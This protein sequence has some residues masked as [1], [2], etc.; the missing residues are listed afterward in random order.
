M[1]F[2]DQLGRP[3][4]LNKIPERL[5]SLVP[6]Q[7]EL[8]ADLGL[9]AYLAGITKFCVHPANLRKTKTIVGGTKK[10]HFDKIKAL[11]P[12]L[13]LCNKEENTKEMVTELEK[14][15]PVH[16]SDI[17][18]VEDNYSL[19]KMYAEML[20]CRQEAS[21]MIDTI[22]K[23]RFGFDKNKTHP[24]TVL[25]FIW[26]DPWMSVGR[27]T[28]IHQMLTENNL[29]NYCEKEVRYPE[30]DLHRLKPGDAP[31][32]IF[33]SSEPYPFKKKHQK[34]L[35]ALFP[36]SNIQLVNG[37]FFSWYGSRLTKAY[38]YFKEL[39]IKIMKI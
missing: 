20:D 11:E 25:Y 4:Q 23:A 18:T 34:E 29:I 10:V 19:I 16:V 35:Q 17:K 8:I 9:E 37:E 33:L 32:L 22:Q 28:F 38:E 31:D 12:E 30:I 24:K 26:K 13:I 3:V 27:D 21:N 2:T 6:S 5:V 14:I 1:N 7:T 39:H 36:K 15:A